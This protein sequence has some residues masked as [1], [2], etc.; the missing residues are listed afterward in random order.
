M[1]WINQLKLNGSDLKK[2]TKSHS[3]STP[4]VTRSNLAEIVGRTVTSYTYRHGVPHRSA[5]AFCSLP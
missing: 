1:A 2:S 3:P 4:K 5:A